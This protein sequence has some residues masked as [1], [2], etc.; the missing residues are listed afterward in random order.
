L[1]WRI[2]H[3]IRSF[4][5]HM[6]QAETMTLAAVV[7]T[8]VAAWCFLEIADEVVEGE[9]HRLDAWVLSALQE[10]SDRAASAR[11]PWLTEIVRDVTA[12]GGIIVLTLVIACTAGYLWI[13]RAYRSMWLVLTAALGGLFLSIL[14]KGVFQ[15]PRPPGTQDLTQVALTSFPSGHTMNS[16]VVYLTLGLL[17]AELAVQARLRVYFLVVALVLTFLVGLSR[18]YLGVHYPSDILAG[19]AA[20]ATW[21]GCCWLVVRYLRHRGRAESL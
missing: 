11:P 16:A 9:T 6:I 19:W 15:R 12:L 2:K 7:L 20:G 13:C 17:L 8:I 1:S 3:T 14:L 10:P 18:V 21:A 4:L 5:Q